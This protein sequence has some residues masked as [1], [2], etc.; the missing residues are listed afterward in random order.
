MVPSSSIFVDSKIHTVYQYQR[1]P[2]SITVQW[3]DNHESKFDLD[4]LVANRP[5]QSSSSPIEARILSNGIKRLDTK[6]SP[7]DSAI[8]HADFMQ[9]D[10]YV[11][12]LLRNITETGFGVISGCPADVDSTLKVH[13]RIS[14]PQRTFYGDGVTVATSD[15]KY[16]DTAYTSEALSLHTDTAYF[17]EP[18]GYAYARHTVAETAKTFVSPPG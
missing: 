13:N 8:A 3:S 15:L 16:N 10:A 14:H 1:S 6:V 18:M 11:G 5:T 17:T 9:N 2:N 12:Q 7:L 4:W